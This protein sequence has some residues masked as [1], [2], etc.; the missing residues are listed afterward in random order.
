MD[1]VRWQRVIFDGPA[2]LG[3]QGMSGARRRFRLSL[4]LDKKS[5]TLRKRED[6]NWNAPF[7]IERPDEDSIQLAGT[8]DGRRIEATLRR[9]NASQFLLTTRGFH[10]INEFPFN[11]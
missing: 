7:T 10:W 4:D 5:L 1:D 3:I 8:M 6:P 9:T 11:R 2:M